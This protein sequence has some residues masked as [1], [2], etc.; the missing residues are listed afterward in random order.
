MPGIIIII[1]LTEHSCIYKSESVKEKGR[2]YEAIN[3]DLKTAQE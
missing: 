1:I 2:S 3:V